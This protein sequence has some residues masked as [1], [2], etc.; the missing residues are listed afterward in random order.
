VKCE[1]NFVEDE[2]RFYDFANAAEQQTEA[3]A[4]GGCLGDG[5]ETN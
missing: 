1:M 5:A 2:P 3:K 4:M